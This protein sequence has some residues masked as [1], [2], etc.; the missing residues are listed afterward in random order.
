MA[1]GS[2]VRHDLAALLDHVRAMC[3]T[4]GLDAARARVD[5][6]GQYN[7]VVVVDERYVIRAPRT[8]KALATMRGEVALLGALAPRLPLAV[9]RPLCWDLDAA[10]GLAF[11]GYENIAGIA[12]ERETYARLA[13]ATVAA[14]ARQVGEF[15]WTLHRTDLKAPPERPPIAADWSSW[16]HLYARIRGCLLPLMRP[17]ARDEVAAHF[18][19]V[20][21]D[22]E[23]WRYEPALIHGDFGTGNILFDE[24]AERVTGV[25][26][27]GSA[28]TGDPA[29]D[30]AAL[31]SRNSL[32][33]EFVG[34]MASTYPGV[35]QLLER[36]DFYRGTFALQYAL[37]GAEMGDDEA[38]RAGLAR[39]R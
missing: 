23:F 12:L 31:T 2:P 32:P 10:P 22:R 29:N 18:E 15:L 27:F 3:P 24:A 25:I 33:V 39:Y 1:A 16:E 4:L 17:D 28:G 5:D 13:P 9:P 30:I 7:L 20:L 21:G 35:S 26:D 8:A 37:Y 6:G 14:I 19:A 11:M 38:L 34:L 36:A